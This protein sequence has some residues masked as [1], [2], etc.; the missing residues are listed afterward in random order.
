MD[1]TGLIW[2]LVIVN[3]GTTEGSWGLDSSDV[4]RVGPGTNGSSAQCGVVDKNL[5]NT[6]G[7]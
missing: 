5:D 4:E 7:R 1:S 2:W 6:C 3:D